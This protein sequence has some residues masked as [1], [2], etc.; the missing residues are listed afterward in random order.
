[1]L[2]FMDKYLALAELKELKYVDDLGDEC[3]L[4]EQYRTSLEGIPRFMVRPILRPGLC[5]Q[6]PLK[7]CGS[8][9]T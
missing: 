6:G 1:M 2:F 8:A 4:I 9:V 5:V 7:S 3:L